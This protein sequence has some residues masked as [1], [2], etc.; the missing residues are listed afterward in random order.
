[1]K[2]SH[3]SRTRAALRQ[4]KLWQ[5][6]PF[7]TKRGRTTVN[8]RPTS[9]GEKEVQG[10]TPTSTT[11]T[12]SKNVW[13]S[14]CHRDLKRSGNAQKQA[15]SHLFSFCRHTCLSFSLIR[16]SPYRPPSTSH[17]SFW[18]PRGLVVFFYVI[19]LPWTK[20]KGFFN[21]PVSGT[22]LISLVNCV[23]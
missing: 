20:R 12:E 5:L 10:R 19:S 7:L 4:K 2:L 21:V 23:S 8:N 22:L 16:T 1:M 13:A 9:R 18:F 17:C 3:Q 11:L 15:P 14:L 6:P